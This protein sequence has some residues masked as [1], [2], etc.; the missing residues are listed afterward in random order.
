MNDKSIPLYESDIS[1]VSLPQSLACL[2]PFLRTSG[3]RYRAAAWLKTPFESD[4]WLVTLAS[5]F[6]IDW[7]IPLG[8]SGTLLTDTSNALLLE[9]FKSWL[10]VQTHPDATGRAMYAPRSAYNTI[11]RALA[12]IDYLLLQADRFNLHSHG[13]S[14]ITAGCWKSLLGNLSKSAENTT[15][16]YEWPSRLEAYVMM[17]AKELSENEKAEAITAFPF[18]AADVTA[19]EDRLTSLSDGAIVDG[20]IWLWTTGRYRKVGSGEHRFD[21]DCSRLARE[22][23]AGTLCG[24]T[25]SLP[26]PPEFSLL[27]GCR[28]RR[29]LDSVPVTTGSEEIRSRR[30]LSRYIQ[31]ISSLQLLRTQSLPIHRIEDA[32]LSEMRSHLILKTTGRFRTPPYAVVMTSLRNAIEFA[33]SNGDQIV[34][35]YLTIARRAKRQGIT[36]RALAVA[37][38]S[39]GELNLTIG[40]MHVTQWSIE[41][42][43]KTFRNRDLF[44]QRLRHSPGIYEL[45][46]ILLGASQIIVGTL[47]ARR[48][49]ELIDLYPDTCMDTTAT[50][51]AFKNR[52]SGPGG[53]R[54]TEL[55]PIPPVCTRVIGTLRRLH[56]G[57]K[58]L[59]VGGTNPLFTYPRSVGAGFAALT[60]PQYCQSIDYFCDFAQ[61]PT[62]THGRRYYLRQHQLRRWFAM[63]FFWGNSFGGVETLRWF[64]GHTDMEHLYHYITETTSGETLRGV[65]AAW[66]VDAIRHETE[67]TKE[68]RAVVK[69]YFGASDLRL[70][71]DEKACIYIEDLMATGS[72]IIEPEFLD[73]GRSCRIC[74]K[75]TPKQEA[76]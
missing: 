20:R 27:P 18:L 76:A 5:S 74:V 56:A 46:R 75:L 69:Q 68:L 49:G 60:P 23:F 12:V 11:R 21:L 7:R 59:G 62:D 33:L 44:F 57:V 52:K 48:V 15:A 72:L 38:A 55:R 4:V 50:W 9:T 22:I 17:G 40:T 29:E 2:A 35:A 6:Q 71:D 30:E 36:P 10:I 42:D 31:T 67:E 64:L 47:S 53:L 65:A 39:A 24:M 16:I 54:E 41:P 66:A 13:V 25:S 8:N 26:V 51:L 3:P 61:V 37:L 58:A 28:F 1:T 34:D 70:I 43:G 14:A 45:I 73:S 32:E 19:A 63:L